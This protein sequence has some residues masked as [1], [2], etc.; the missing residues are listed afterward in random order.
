MYSQANGSEEE[1]E[2]FPEFED[3]LAL[4]EEVIPETPICAHSRPE[5]PDAGMRSLDHCMH[6]PIPSSSSPYTVS[7]HAQNHT[8]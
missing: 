6:A 2:K 8:L 1:L 4:L 3:E 7:F 5:A